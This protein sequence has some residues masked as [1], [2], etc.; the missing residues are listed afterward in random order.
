MVTALEFHPSA[1]QQLLASGGGPNDCSIRFYDLSNPNAKHAMR[2]ISEVLP[3][4]SLAFHPSGDYLLV[5]C[6]HPTRTRLPL[7]VLANGTLR[8][9]SDIVE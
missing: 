1:S 7:P 3:I 8:I 2:A 4:N 9:C 5:A 6:D